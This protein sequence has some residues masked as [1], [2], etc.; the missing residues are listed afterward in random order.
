MFVTLILELKYLTLKE[1]NFVAVLFR[2]SSD[3]LFPLFFPLPYQVS[4]LQH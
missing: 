1:L 2:E 4:L 3:I